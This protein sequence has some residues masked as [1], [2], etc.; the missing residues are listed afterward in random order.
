MGG[1][2][3]LA[4]LRG[5]QEHLLWERLAHG[6]EGRGPGRRGREPQAFSRPRGAGGRERRRRDVPPLARRRLWRK[7]DGGQGRGRHHLHSHELSR[8]LRRHRLQPRV[9]GDGGRGHDRGV[10]EGEGLV[11]VHLVL[12]GPR[13]ELVHRRKDGDVLDVAE[14]ARVREVPK[15]E[16][17]PR[18]DKIRDAP[19][20][21]ALS[22]S[23]TAR[24][25]VSCASSDVRKPLSS[26]LL[27]S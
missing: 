3:G 17:L 11:V 24:R 14:D 9:A 16:V 5:A 21:V 7:V 25:K 6:G 18:T 27:R 20:L 1:A 8:R 13:A 12:V 23:R 26:L 2:S 4:L 19:S 10:G 15:S 22:A